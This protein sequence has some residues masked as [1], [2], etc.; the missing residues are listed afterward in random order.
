MN[1]ISYT[2]D[3]RQATEAMVYL[4]GLAGGTMNYMKAIKILYLADRDSILRGHDP[5]TT[6]SYKSMKFGP[7]T[8]CIYD[9]IKYGDEELWSTY[10]R[11]DGYEISKKADIEYNM[12]SIAERKTISSVYEKFKDNTQYQLAEYCHANLPEWEDP[13][14]SSIPIS[15]EAIIESG[16]LSPEMKKDVLEELEVGSW[17]QKNNFRVQKRTGLDE[18]R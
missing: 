1:S 17:I 10:I 13:H 4:L 18:R 15:I 3:I 14:G 12:L 8:S 5:I 7:V 6:D 16:D 2:F 9:C 11:K